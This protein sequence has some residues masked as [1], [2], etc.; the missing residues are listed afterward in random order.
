MDK[1]LKIETLNE[2]MMPPDGMPAA[3]LNQEELVGF[4]RAV[5]AGETVPTQ[6]EVVALCNALVMM[7][8]ALLSVVLKEREEE[9]AMACFVASKM[10][11]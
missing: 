9:G 5:L 6:E 7:S 11:M 3:P 10:A 4:A 2:E 8:T 1:R